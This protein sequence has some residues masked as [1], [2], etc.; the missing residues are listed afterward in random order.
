MPIPTTKFKNINLETEM[1]V[2]ET[3]KNNFISTQ[4][5]GENNT[6]NT[7]Y[8]MCIGANNTAGVKAWY[9][10]GIDKAN[11]YIYL[12]DDIAQRGNRT[13]IHNESFVSGFQVNDIVT[14]INN[15]N[16]DV[17]YKVLEV[18]GNR[19]KLDS[20]PFDNV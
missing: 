4:G 6:I 2:A 20:I 9:W 19:I 5:F 12:T 1:M 10:T 14:I 16:Y 11:N 8:T 18:S 3:I 15:S 7:R 13:T 17:G